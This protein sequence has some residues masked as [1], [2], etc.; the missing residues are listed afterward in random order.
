MRRLPAVLVSLA[1]LLAGALPAGAAKPTKVTIPI[2]DWVIPFPDECPDFE[3]EATVNGMVHVITFVDA[4]GN[5]TS[6]WQGGQLFVTWTRLDTSASLTLA[7]SGPTFY[8]ASGTAVFGTGRWT[9]P[10]DGDGWVLAIGMLTLDGYD[11][12]GWSVIGSYAGRATSICD[13]MA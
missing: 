13:L 6:G 2:E 4:D 11:A 1:I 7:I 12:D 8:D 9:T 5:P 10:L 3:L